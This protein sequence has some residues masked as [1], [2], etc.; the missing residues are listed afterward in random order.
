M[1]ATGISLYLLVRPVNQ[2]IASPLSL[3]YLRIVRMQF[4]D[5]QLRY[6]NTRLERWLKADGAERHVIQKSINEHFVAN[7]W[8]TQNN[9]TAEKGF[10]ASISVRIITRTV[11]I[12]ISTDH[13]ELSEQSKS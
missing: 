10:E 4:T 2:Y 1:F 12:M 13:S 5:R 11:L 3:T 6:M 7:K 8:Y 9:V